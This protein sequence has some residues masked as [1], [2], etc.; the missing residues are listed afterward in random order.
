[1]IAVVLM[2]NNETIPRSWNYTDFS[3]FSHKRRKKRSKEYDEQ[4]IGNETIYLDLFLPKNEL[5][6][7]Q[8]A[9]AEK[10]VFNFYG[11]ACPGDFR[12]KFFK[13]D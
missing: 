13:C 11:M 1:M 3:A 9:G 4:T 10:I 5:D 8:T 6:G 12:F 2:L 7:S